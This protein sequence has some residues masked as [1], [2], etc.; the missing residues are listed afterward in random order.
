M[1]TKAKQKTAAA[2][3][4]PSPD[5]STLISAALLNALSARGTS[6]ATDSLRSAVATGS[7]KLDESG[8]PIVEFN[9][10][11]GKIIV[12]LVLGMRQRMMYTL[13]LWDKKGNNKFIRDGVSWD[14]VPDIQDIDPTPDLDNAHL[15]WD[16]TITQSASGPGDFYY[17]AL[18][19]EQDGAALCPLFENFG[20][21]SGTEIVS[22]S[23]VFKA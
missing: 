14:N 21:L 2:A 22:G 17:F 16:V 10:K 18:K 9:P 11:G 12:T 19:V 6:T 5:V 1:A 23:L 15:F 20:P 8:F 13:A 7:V 3:A 4:V